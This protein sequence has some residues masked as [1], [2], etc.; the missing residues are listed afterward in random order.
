MSRLW[1]LL[2]LV[3]LVFLAEFALAGPIQAADLTGTWTGTWTKNG[4]AL[5]VTVT[6][7]ATANG[8][9]G[10][11]DSDPLEVTG[12]AFTSVQLDGT[13]LEF[14]LTGDES[15]IVFEG[16][17]QNHSISG[18][19]ADASHPVGVF[20]LTRA[21]ATS[22]ALRTREVSF[23]SGGA[24]ISGTLVLPEQVGPHPAIVFLHG[25][26]DEYRWASLY[27][28]RRLAAAGIAAL[29][30]DKRGVGKSTGRWQDVGFDALAEDGAAG[31]RFLRTQPEIN[32]NRIGLNGQSQGGTIAP[33]AATKANAAFVIAA[34]PG[35]IEPASLEEY[36][37]DNDIGVRTLPPDEVADAKSFVRAFVDVAYRGKPRS[38]L[39]S[40]AA[41]FK[42]RSWYFDPPPPDNYYWAFARRIAD[43]RPADYW[44]QVK[45]P[46]LLLFGA[47]D[48]RVPPKESSAAIIAAMRAAGNADVTLRVFPEAD[49][50]FSLPTSNGGWGRREPEFANTIVAWASQHGKP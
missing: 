44:R 30:T 26:G 45:V 41:N 24:T 31:V 29:V 25:S 47:R 48:E 22:P 33:L 23:V 40:L 50:T 17:L 3:G 8:F 39:D 42:G 46:V 18:S 11:F 9:S 34:A 20:K 1:R 36:S 14:V 4:D 43:Y 49:H 38:E 19:F 7:A 16:T 32:P 5:P 13:K 21:M 37:L 12:I 10:M 2:A 28:A 15:V 6:F 35:G 27:R